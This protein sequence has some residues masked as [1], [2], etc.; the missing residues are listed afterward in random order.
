MLL[1]FCMII[2]QT[3]KTATYTFTHALLDLAI[4]LAPGD[5]RF[6][7]YDD[8]IDVLAYRYVT[9]CFIL[10]NMALVEVLL[11][12]FALIDR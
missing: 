4:L 12:L 8:A 9:P 6:Y 10:A 2:M 11:K 5:H 7:P 1:Y 3:E